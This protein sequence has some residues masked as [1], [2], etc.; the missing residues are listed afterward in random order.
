V[1]R[2]SWVFFW[3]V[4]SGRNG[5]WNNIFPSEKRRIMGNQNQNKLKKRQKEMERMRKAREK[6]AKRQGKDQ[7]REHTDLDETPRHP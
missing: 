6:M 7:K 5:Y 2:G 4:P 3:G 1:N